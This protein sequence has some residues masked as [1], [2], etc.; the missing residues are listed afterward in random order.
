MKVQ[1]A[2]LA[3]VVSVFKLSAAAQAS[4]GGYVPTAAFQAPKAHRP[5]VA[6]VKPKASAPRV[7]VKAAPAAAAAAPAP[8]RQEASHPRLPRATTGNPSE[9]PRPFLGIAGSRGDIQH[10]WTFTLEAA[11]AKS[12]KILRTD[13]DSMELIDELAAGS[14]TDGRGLTLGDVAG[15]RRDRYMASYRA[16]HLV[17]ALTRIS[18]LSNKSTIRRI[19]AEVQDKTGIQ[20]F[21][22]AHILP[23]DFEINGKAGLHL[24]FVSP[25]ISNCVQARLFGVTNVVHR[26]VN[27]ADQRCEDHGWK[28]TFLAATKSVME[29]ADADQIYSH[30]LVPGYSAAVARAREVLIAALR[31]GE[32]EAMDKPTL[33]APNGEPAQR[34]A[35]DFRI[36]AKVGDPKVSGINKGAVL[37]VFEEYRLG[38]AGLAPSVFAQARDEARAWAE[39]ERQWRAKHA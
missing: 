25:I 2:Q 1:A 11:M 19:G 20:D 38:A 5:A 35:Q 6:A 14:T 9:H 21:Q 12:R 16:L 13:I 30:T 28:A 22:A 33:L 10:R 15:H 7:A 34:R 17:G 26:L 39:L 32:R 23:C 31:K 18:L 27:Y 3:E 29:G 36:S 24:L 37:Q 4:Q 8:T